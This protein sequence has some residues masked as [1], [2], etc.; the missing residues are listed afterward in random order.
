MSLSCFVRFG[1]WLVGA[2][3]LKGLALPEDWGAW[4]VP[5]ALCVM[6]DDSSDAR[7]PKLLKID[8]V[9]VTFECFF[10]FR[11][12]LHYTGWEINLARSWA[13]A[14]QGEA[15]MEAEAAWCCMQVC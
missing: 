14:Q 8:S 13:V 5:W 7:A 2:V 3:P 10:P 1:C 11:G 15:E 6:Q 9:L 4:H 12:K